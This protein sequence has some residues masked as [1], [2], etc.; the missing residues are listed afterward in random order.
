M[1]SK[2]HVNIFP[3]QPAA[4]RRGARDFQN[5]EYLSKHIHNLGKRYDT[6]RCSTYNYIQLQ[7]LG[8]RLLVAPTFTSI[9]LASSESLLNPTTT[10]APPPPPDHLPPNTVRKYN[11]TGQPRDKYISNRSYPQDYLVKR[12]K[13]LQRRKRRE[14]Y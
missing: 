10:T 4:C 5:N 3:Q 2:L 14:R 6:A 12:S 8:T 7:R 13:V 11:K 1:P 9:S